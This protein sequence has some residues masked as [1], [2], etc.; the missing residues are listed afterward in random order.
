MVPVVVAPRAHAQIRKAVERWQREHSGA[1]SRLG[2]K[3]R[4]RSSYW[5]RSRTSASALADVAAD[6][7]CFPT[8][9]TTSTTCVEPSASRS[10]P[11][12]TPAADV[13]RDDVAAAAQ[14]VDKRGATAKELANYDPSNGQWRTTTRAGTPWHGSIGSSTSASPDG[15]LSR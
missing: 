13:L 4:V 2:R 7:C 3:S 9:A 11:C 6:D 5:Q 15:S 1:T 14:L 10:S 8:L 12:G